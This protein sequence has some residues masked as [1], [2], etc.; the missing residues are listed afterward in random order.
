[1]AVAELNINGGG[2]GEWD[3]NA[4]EKQIS[5]HYFFTMVQNAVSVAASYA[6]PV[7]TL[8]M[9]LFYIA[10]PTIIYIKYFITEW[11]CITAVE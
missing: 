8:L 11:K 9:E 10:Q 1:M 5:Q 2:A 4:L 6:Y 7:E 3:L